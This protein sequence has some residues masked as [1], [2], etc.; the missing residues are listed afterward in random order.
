[1]V[2]PL[3]YLLLN[4]NRRHRPFADY[5]NRKN[6]QHSFPW[7]FRGRGAT[8]LCTSSLK[9]NK[10]DM[11]KIKR[12]LYM[13]FGTDPFVL[14]QQFLG[15]RLLPCETIDASLQISYQIWCKNGRM[16]LCSR[17]AEW[18]QSGFESNIQNVWTTGRPAIGLSTQPIHSQGSW[19]SSS[20]RR[21]NGLKSSIPTR[22]TNT[23]WF[24]W[25]W[26]SQ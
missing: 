10:N 26:K 6:Q 9:R 14:Y 19:N 18:R 17:I 1:M 21:K 8:T 3:A 5:A 12:A 11:T 7:G 23:N 13:A 22:E 25:D 2:L 15:R 4:G 20:S 16:H 24:L